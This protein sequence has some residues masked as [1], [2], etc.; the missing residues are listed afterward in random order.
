M[1]WTEIK[2]APNGSH[3]MYDLWEY[4]IDYVSIKNDV[5]FEA[6]VYI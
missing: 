3:P 5:L 2:Q 6:L 1:K 4:I